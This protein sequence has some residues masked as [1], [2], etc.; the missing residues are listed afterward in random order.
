VTSEAGSYVA[1]TRLW[2][3]APFIV[4]GKLLFLVAAFVQDGRAGV[5]ECIYVYF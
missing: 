2:L 4:V 3:G 1:T 5:R